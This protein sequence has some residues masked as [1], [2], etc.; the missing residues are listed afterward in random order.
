MGKKKSSWSRILNVP[1]SKSEMNHMFPVGDILLYVLRYLRRK[2]VGLPREK[3]R[4]N[5]QRNGKP[6][7]EEGRLPILW[8]LIRNIQK[9]SPLYR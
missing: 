6:R 7:N 5:L 1:T 2:S 9:L 3:C 8:F 4:K